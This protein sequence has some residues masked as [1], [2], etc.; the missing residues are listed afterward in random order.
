MI[1]APGGITYPAYVAV[2]SA[3]T[4]R[5]VLRRPGN[6]LDGRRCSQPDQSVTVGGRTYYLYCSGQ[7]LRVVAWY[8]HGAVYWVHNTLTDAVGNGELLA[9]AEQTRADRHPGNPREPDRYQKRRPRTAISR[10]SSSPDATGAD[11][12]HV[13]TIETIGSIGGLLTLVAVPLLCIA[14]LRRRR[15]LA[16]LRSELDALLSLEH[17]LRSSVPRAPAV[18]ERSTP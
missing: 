1:H 18:V 3:G 2:F 5:P 4:A 17:R 6:D 11:H 9:I 16:A 8:E 15:R 14:L 7:H 13:A 10:P 12:E